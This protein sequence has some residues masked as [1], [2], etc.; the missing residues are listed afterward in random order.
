MN[1]MGFGTAL[2]AV[3][4][5]Y[6]GW[7]NIAPVAEEVREPSR[8]IPLSLFVGV[9]VLIVLYCGANFAYYLIIP[10]P[11][12]AGLKNTTVATEFCQRLLGP[13]GAI[14]A[15]AIVMTSVFGALNGNLLVGPR[16][17]YAMGHDRLAPRLLS[18]LHTKYRTPAVA[19]AVMAGW[20]CLLVVG[21]GALTQYRLPTIPLGATELDLNIPAGK[22]PF[23]VMTDF[24]IFG[25]VTFETLA[26][27]SIFVFRRRIPV[28]PE[29][30]PYRCWGY[31][32]VPAVYIAIMA[33][34][35]YTFFA[36][37]EQRSEALGV[38]FIGIGAIVYFTMFRER[39]SR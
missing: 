30:R 9:L 19:T 36:S 7:M 6:N 33:G 1:W 38:G 11:E 27:A 2:I 32:V 24:A 34:V 16:L 14:I 39:K 3:L 15:S 28:T 21:V 37:A 35:I 10:C 17:L 20:S 26:V 29:N 5:A 18:Q 12:M 4:W 31:P 13:V 8:N 22:S 23:D 25:S